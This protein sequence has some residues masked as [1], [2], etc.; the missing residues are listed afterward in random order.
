MHANHCP[1]CDAPYTLTSAPCCPEMQR[2]E[3]QVSEAARATVTEQDEIENPIHDFAAAL[4]PAG[5]A[6]ADALPFALTPEPAAL[7]PTETQPDL[8]SPKEPRR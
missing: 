4:N 1:Y 6:L 8:F 7:E 2:H 3:H 5:G